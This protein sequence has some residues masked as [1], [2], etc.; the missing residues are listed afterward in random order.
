MSLLSIFSLLNCQFSHYLTFSA[1]KIYLNQITIL[2][3][4][5]SFSIHEWN[6]WI[7]KLK[8]ISIFY[9][10]GQSPTCLYYVH[11]YLI[12]FKIFANLINQK[13]LQ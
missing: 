13:K 4:S 10:L 12:F 3:S 7:I 6:V 11:D 1:K 5:S 8:S 9:A 2:D